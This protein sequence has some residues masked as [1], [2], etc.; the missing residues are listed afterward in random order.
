MIQWET[1]NLPMTYLFPFFAYKVLW[2][3]CSCYNNY[4]KTIP[5]NRY[6]SSLINIKKGVRMKFKQ[7]LFGFVI[8]GVIG[9]IL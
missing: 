2:Q 7:F 6:Y 9:V 3:V 1:I 5:V 4:N 8:L